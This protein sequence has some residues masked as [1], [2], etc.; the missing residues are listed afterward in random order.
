MATDATPRVAP[1]PPEERDERQAALVGKAGRE[2]NVFTT[3]VRHTDL[4]ADF[5]PFGRRLLARSSLRPRDRELLIM[6]AAWRC[7]ARYEWSHHE[8]IGRSAG[9]TDDDL[10]ALATDP[11][12]DG[13]DPA[14]GLL[15]RAADELITE[16]AL[17]DR[18][19][20]ELTEDRSVEQIIEICM[21]VGEYA[22]LAGVLNSLRVQIEPG[23]PTPAWAQR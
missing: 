15:L 22:M 4:F 2:F 18:S 9:L 3:L 11:V 20:A 17:T 19:W 6:R 10:I 12:D 14:R 23:Y 1:L 16:H 21:L 7:G 13:A 5:L 8:V